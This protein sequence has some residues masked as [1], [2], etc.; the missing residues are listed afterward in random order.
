MRIPTG[1]AL[2][3]AA[4]AAAL[5]LLPARA[6]AQTCIADVSP[7]RIEAGTKA[8]P[9][10]VTVPQPIGALTGIDASRTSGIALALPRDLPATEAGALGRPPRA[11]EKGEAEN[12]FIV[13]LSVSK[14]GPGTHAVTFTAREGRCGAELRVEAAR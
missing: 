3:A 8:V 12:V 4:F 1:R 9:I 7:A 10:R 13:W 11:I 5:A 2:P 14:A 6:D